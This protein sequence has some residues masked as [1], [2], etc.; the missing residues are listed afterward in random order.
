MRKGVKVT[1]IR[2]LKM[3]EAEL[4]HRI[5]EGAKIIEWLAGL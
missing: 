5:G 4:K 3:L 1:R 2:E